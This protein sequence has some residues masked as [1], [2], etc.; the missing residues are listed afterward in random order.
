MITPGMC[1]ERLKNSSRTSLYITRKR[2][3]GMITPSTVVPLSPCSVWAS[4]GPM[5]NG[6]FRSL[7]TSCKNPT[8]QKT[9]IATAGARRNWRSTAASGGSA[10]ANLV[11]RS[12]PKCRQRRHLTVRLNVYEEEAGRVLLQVLPMPEWKKESR[13]GPREA[14]IQ[15]SRDSRPLCRKSLSMLKDPQMSWAWTHSVAKLYWR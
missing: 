8:I 11:I 7:C 9:C 13:F 6:L 15:L 2:T 4:S 14:L 10:E 12:T 3:G 1:R 5:L